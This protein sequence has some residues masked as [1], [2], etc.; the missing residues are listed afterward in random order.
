MVFTINSTFVLVNLAKVIQSRA[1]ILSFLCLILNYGESSFIS[2]VCHFKTSE[3]ELK[4]AV[5]NHLK[6]TMVS[7]RALT[8]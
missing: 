8:K 6:F 4:C 3:L 7:K 2:S 5:Q 1:V